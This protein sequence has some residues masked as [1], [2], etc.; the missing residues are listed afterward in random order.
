[1]FALGVTIA[2]FFTECSEPVVEDLD[3]G[4]DLDTMPPWAVS[5]TRKVRLCL[6]LASFSLM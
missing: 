2:A 6:W 5:A 1:M 4:E 3:D